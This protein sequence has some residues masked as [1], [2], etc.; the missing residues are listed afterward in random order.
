MSEWPFLPLGTVVE[1]EGR[2]FELG[3]ISRHVDV[4][5]HHHEEREWYLVSGARPIDSAFWLYP[6]WDG[7]L[8]EPF[9]MRPL[10][11]SEPEQQIDFIPSCSKFGRFYIKTPDAIQ[12]AD[13]IVRLPAMAA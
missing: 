10:K 2:T 5:G 8:K 1:H 13:L 7:P 6:D 12:V 3:S 9:W 11:L 4:A